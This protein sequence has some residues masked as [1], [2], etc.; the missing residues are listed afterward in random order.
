MKYL[1]EMQLHDQVNVYKR[2]P[3]LLDGNARADFVSWNVLALEDELHEAL[4]EIQYKVWLTYGR[5]DWV[6]RDAYVAELCADALRFFIN[7]ILV[8]APPGTSA[9]VIYEEL[10]AR[11]VA[12]REVNR[13]RQRDGYDGRKDADGREVDRL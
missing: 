8:A 9:D 5:G 13:T 7:L 4:Q 6:D 11:F 1:I 2:D 3:R 12:K 10:V